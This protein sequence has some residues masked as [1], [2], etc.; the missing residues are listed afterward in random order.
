MAVAATTV[1]EI[2]TGGNDDNGGG[3]NAALAGT[4]YTL[5]DA[6]QLSLTDLACASNT[7]LTSATGGFT[8]AMAGNLIH[9]I[10]GTND[11]PGWYEITAVASSN[12]VTIDRT[13]ATGGNMTDGVGKVGGALASI[14]GLGAVLTTAGGGGGVAGL[15]AYIKG[16]T[17]NLTATVVNT[18]GGPLDLDATAQDSFRFFLKGY[19]AE[20]TRDSLTGTRPII[21]CATQTPATAA[22]IKL[23]GHY[24]NVHTISFLDIDGDSLTTYGILGVSIS[25]RALFCQVRDCNGAAGIANVL[26]ISSKVYSCSVTGFLECQCWGCWADSNGATGFSSITAVVSVMCLATNNN[27]GI[28]N[29]YTGAT[30]CITYNNA[31]HG[32]SSNLNGKYINCFSYLDGGYAFNTTA[33]DIMVNCAS[34]N[35]ASGHVNVQPALNLGSITG[36]TLT[37]DPFT[38]KANGDFSLNAAAAGGALLRAAGL[39]PYGQTGYLDIGAVQHADP[40][41]PSEWDVRRYTDYGNNEYEGR[42]VIPDEADVKAGVTYGAEDADGPEYTGTYSI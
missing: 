16:G 39:N 19:S 12:S 1:Y 15:K 21:D 23:K 22:V 4:D 34:R 40:D 35:L 25:D 5:Q 29:R 28:S 11:A 10:S 32:Y 14:G 18:A 31:S 3:F 42:L 20:A 9:I 13:C 6:A 33:Q 17:Y 26:A 27:V 36:A 8:A 37:D 30:S 7:T 41:Q 24:S 38:D 2:R